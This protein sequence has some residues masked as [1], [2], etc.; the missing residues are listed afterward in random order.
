MSEVVLRSDS[1]N[2][3]TY[4]PVSESENEK[5]VQ[6]TIY[7]PFKN[8]ERFFMLL[9]FDPAEKWDEE[10][11]V[12]EA[13]RDQGCYNWKIASMR[14]KVLQ[15]LPEEDRLGAI[16][17]HFACRY[18]FCANERITEWNWMN[19][20][21]NDVRLKPYDLCCLVVNLTRKHPGVMESK[22]FDVPKPAHGSESEEGEKLQKLLV[23]HVIKSN[24]DL[25]YLTKEKTYE[26][27][28]ELK[29]IVPS[30]SEV[31]EHLKDGVHTHY[32]KQEFVESWEEV[33]EKH[34]KEGAV[35]RIRD[36][37]D[38]IRILQKRIWEAR[39]KLK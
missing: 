26:R 8:N 23:K 17:S 30:R 29:G 2:Q 33:R 38:D 24:K 5:T 36:Q 18:L 1:E 14:S 3:D 32:K 11:K 20:C 34:P 16:V 13:L 21:V 27:F 31:V 28:P 35:Q 12:L 39:A 25:D 19:I 22:Y 9:P 15:S 7:L 10:F 6:D 37:N 4:I